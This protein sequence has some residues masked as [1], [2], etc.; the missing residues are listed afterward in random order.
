MYML[1]KF[2]ELQNMKCICEKC[3]PITQYDP[4]Q[5]DFASW[6]NLLGKND[7]ICD[8]S[9]TVT[10][11]M[12]T[13]VELP[14]IATS[15][16]DINIRNV[17]RHIF[18]GHGFFAYKMVLTTSLVA[19]EPSNRCIVKLFIPTVPCKQVPEPKNNLGRIEILQS[20]NIKHDRNFAKFRCNGALV[21]EGN[22][23]S[24][25]D[26]S[27][28]YKQ[29][30]WVF[31][32]Y[33]LGNLDNECQLTCSGGIHFFLTE[34]APEW[35][36]VEYDD[37]EN[38]LYEEYNDDGVLINRGMLKNF[39]KHGEWYEVDDE[40]FPDEYSIINYDNGTLHGNYTKYSR[41]G[42]VLFTDEY[43]YGSRLAGRI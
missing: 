5:A 13:T 10:N 29:G 25:H 17:A 40:R 30:E 39:Q 21:V 34:K 15:L 27:F 14:D 2:C 26:S 38:G 22:G 31:P 41:I 3:Q 32:S 23:Y 19:Y 7:D 42:A 20:K 8:I 18:Q 28:R 37:I 12:D 35:F 43:H 1:H 24:W 9:S 33:Y 11:N 36:L 4:H 6:E 16:P